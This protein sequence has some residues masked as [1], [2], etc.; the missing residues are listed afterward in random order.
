MTSGLMS[1]S[2]SL[3]GDVARS[4]AVV[5][6]AQGALRVADH[7]CQRTDRVEGSMNVARLTA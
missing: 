3:I 5:R 1:G 2:V 4:G 7:P 6:E